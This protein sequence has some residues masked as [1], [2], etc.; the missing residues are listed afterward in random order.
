MRHFLFGLVFL[1]ACNQHN[2]ENDAKVI[3]QTIVTARS[4]ETYSLLKCLQSQQVASIT[5]NVDDN[6]RG[7]IDLF[8]VVLNDNL[9]FGKDASLHWANTANPKRPINWHHRFV[10]PR[11]LIPHRESEFV[12]IYP[13]DPFTFT[14]SVGEGDCP[15]QPKA[16]QLTVTSIFYRHVAMLEETELKVVDGT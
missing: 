11:Q 15:E 6:G 16:G 2:S 9:K 1:T 3:M 12:T 4:N 13:N 7:A 10:F 8:K 14:V 5:V